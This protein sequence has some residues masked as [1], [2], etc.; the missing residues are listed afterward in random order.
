MVGHARRSTM[1]R[2]A[3]RTTAAVA[4]CVL[5]GPAWRFAAQEAPPGE[6]VQAHEDIRISLAEV[7]ALEQ[8]TLEQML[9][10]DDWAFRALGLMRLDRYRADEIGRFLTE[11][12]SDP[13]WQ[14]RC[15]AIR[16]A[17]RAGVAIDPAAFAGEQDTRVIRALVQHGVT[18]DPL[19]VNEL[20]ERLLKMRTVDAL[21]MGIEIGAAATDEDVREH[22]SQRALTLV[23][24]M[25]A[26]IGAVVTRRLAAAVGLE[27]APRNLEQWR[28]WLMTVPNDWRLPQPRPPRRPNTLTLMAGAD[29]ESFAR[30]RDYMGLLSRRDLEMALAIDSTSSMAP[31]IDEVKA[32][33]DGLL[34]FLTDI[35][36]SARLGLLAY[37]D[38]DNPGKLVEGHPLSTDVESLRN[39]LFGLQTPGGA[40]L[41]ESVLAGLH[42]CRQ[43]EWSEQAEREII[44]IGDAPPHEKDKSEVRS[45][46]E[47]FSSQG[48]T[49]HAVH[50]PSGSGDSQYALETQMVFQQ[51]ANFGGGQLVQLDVSSQDDLVR[52]VMR[53]TIEKQWWPY[54]DEFYDSY[55]ELCR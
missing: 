17:W 37:R 39:F 8:Q 36:A 25:N 23:R 44:I 11:A 45:L 13:S 41:P 43:F 48:F 30:L 47:W 6:Q 19:V 29:A 24:N 14:G 9:E 52:S 49:V 31:V 55:L 54:F 40:T 10:A 32:G 46:L 20:T 4:A 18:V 26:Q 12:L 5:M 3:V 35:S 38:T 15:Y 7:P 22:A 33:V 16:H 27:T 50:V 1:S 34:L 2:S 28:A 21:L 42:G 51:M 53:L